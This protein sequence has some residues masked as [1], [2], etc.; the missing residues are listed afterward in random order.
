[1]QR[2]LDD[3]AEVRARLAATQRFRGLS[4]WAAIGSGIVAVA[5][6]GAQYA[7][8]PYPKTQ[9]DGAHFVALWGVCLAFALALNYGA[10]GIWYARHWS[11][12]S[13]IELR[14]VGL[15]IVPAIVV[16]GILT[17]ALVIRGDYDVLPATWM[18]AYAV[19]RFASRALVPP[20]VVYVAVFFAALGAAFALVPS[21]VSL[22]WWVMPLAF[23]IGQT[24]IGAIV[25]RSE[26]ETTRAR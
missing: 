8:D 4:G 17:A 21:A 24:A 2:A 19:G 25:L 10:I 9:L 18:L 11:S 26:Q 20:S 23:G 1:M 3:L 13:G 22:A 15:T 7:L 5:C 16:G 6:G 12:R 14:T